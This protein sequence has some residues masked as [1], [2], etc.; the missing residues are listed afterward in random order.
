MV[1]RRTLIGSAGTLFAGATGGCIGSGG[2]SNDRVR[3]QE[4]V[5]GHPVLAGETVDALDDW[6]VHALSANDGSNRWT[7]EYDDSEFDEPLC[8]RQ[9]LAADGRHL[10]LPG[11]DGIRALERSDGSQS[12]AVGAPIR[13]GVA[14]AEGRVYANAGDQLAIDAATGSVEWRASVGGDRL[15]VPAAMPEAVVFANRPDGVIAAFDPDGDRRWTHRTG[16]ETRS[17]TIAD[18]TVYVGTA[19]G[20]GREGRL[21]A[22]DLEGGSERWAVDTPTL[23]RGTRPAVGQ[24]AVYLGCSGRD[25]GRLVALDRSDGTERWRVTDD[26]STV[27]QPVLADGTVYAG[28]NDDTL[29]AYTTAGERQ[30]TV[31]TDSTVGAV[32]AGEELVYASNNERLLAVERG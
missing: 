3:W 20:P 8:L 22:L 16:T 7:V 24:D 19:P 6:T 25:T 31:E 5:R 4:R 27:Y 32:V 12:W 2:P 9:H 11:C 18:G 29:Y 15:A 26:N 17:P 1:S 30:W 28:S 13:H 10:Y 21:L 14:T 23:K